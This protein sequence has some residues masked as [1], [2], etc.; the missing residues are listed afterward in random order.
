[1]LAQRECAIETCKDENGERTKFRT[2]G[3]SPYCYN[4]RINID[5]WSKRKPAS[6]MKRIADLAR[7]SARMSTLRVPISKSNIVRFRKRA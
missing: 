7:F 2:R 3:D 6:V 4:C 1:M 5:T